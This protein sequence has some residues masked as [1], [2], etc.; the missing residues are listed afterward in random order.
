M[1]HLNWVIWGKVD[2]V[3]I[4]KG[5]MKFQ[6]LVKSGGSVT[7]PRPRQE[8]EW[9]VIGTQIQKWLCLQ[10]C[11]IRA[12]SY[13]GHCQLEWVQREW[14][15]LSW[16]TFL[17]FLTSQMDMQSNARGQGS[18][19]GPQ[20]SASQDTEQ[21]ENGG[22]E[23]TKIWCPAQLSIYR[24]GRYG[25]LVWCNDSILIRNLGTLVKNKDDIYLSLK[26]PALLIT[27]VKQTEFFQ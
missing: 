18:P 9:V 25:V 20:R 12:P 2:K 26:K 19:Y 23:G 5:L 3:T 4:Y 16:T 6:E 24:Q 14:P 7:N 8:R 27:L 10:S 13:K 1:A 15:G 22:F 21:G 11:L 17:Y